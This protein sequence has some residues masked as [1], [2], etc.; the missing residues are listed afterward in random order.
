MQLENG[1]AHGRPP[2]ELRRQPLPV[3]IGLIKVTALLGTNTT[4]RTPSAVSKAVA[5]RS[6]GD[7]W[8]P[9]V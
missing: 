9:T 5:P 4:V 6:D 3:L 7:D 1:Q 2:E 8:C